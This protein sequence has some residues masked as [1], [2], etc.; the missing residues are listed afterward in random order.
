MSPDH[1]YPNRVSYGDTGG[2]SPLKRWV[3]V[4]VSAI[5]VGGGGAAIIVGTMDPQPSTTPAAAATSVPPV[6]V[7]APLGSLLPSTA[8]GLTARTVADRLA[9]LYPLPNLRDNTG[10][11]RDAG[12]VEAIT[13]DAVTVLRFAD[14]TQAQKWVESFTKAGSADARRAGVFVL[15]WIAKSEQDWTSA[16]AR[17]AMHKELQRIVG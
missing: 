12:V 6:P 2:M 5:S 4:V 9:H 16:E 7:P 10:Y 8:S 3:L 14:E 15:S 17:E 1:P 13:T 11:G